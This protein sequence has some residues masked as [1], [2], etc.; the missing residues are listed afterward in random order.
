M[1]RSEAFIRSKSDENRRL[2]ITKLGIS[3]RK[4]T[5]LPS[6]G[7]PKRSPSIDLTIIHVRERGELESLA[8]IDDNTALPTNLPPP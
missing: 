1:R 8:R 7:K 3:Y 2:A 6:I 4:A 5:V